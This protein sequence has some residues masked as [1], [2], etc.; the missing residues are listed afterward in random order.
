LKKFGTTG[1]TQNKTHTHTH[2]QTF[3]TKRDERMKQYYV[4]RQY[5]S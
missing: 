2:L 4:V 1:R 3:N 5:R